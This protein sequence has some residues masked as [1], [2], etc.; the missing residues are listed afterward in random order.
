MYKAL[1]ENRL[2]LA[3]MKLKDRLMGHRVFVRVVLERYNK[4]Q[5]RRWR[6]VSLWACLYGHG[7]TTSSRGM[8]ESYV[9]SF[10]QTIV[11]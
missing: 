4:G 10:N 5:E 9:A 2:C 1:F 8:L 6:P 7:S 11:A 3:D